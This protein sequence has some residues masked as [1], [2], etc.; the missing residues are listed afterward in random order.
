MRRLLLL[1]VCVL[2]VVGC[3]KPVKVQ[4]KVV[5]PIEAVELL[6]N[7]DVQLIDV[8][9]P[10]EY[11]EGYIENAKN[12]NFYSN[13]FG[14]EIEALDKQ[15]PVIVYCKKGGRSAKSVIKLKEA[16]FT[17][18]YDLEGGISKWKEEGYKTK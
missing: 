15:S 13:T 10:E 18:I 7:G 6:N 14:S 11:N 4:S 17:K 8:R 1:L 9:T 3:N 5:S 2:S 12:I 16:G